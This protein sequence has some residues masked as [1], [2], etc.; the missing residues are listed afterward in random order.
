MHLCLQGVMKKLIE[1]WMV[2]DLTIRFRPTIKKEL[3]RRTKYLKDQVPGDFQRKMRSISYCA[4]WKA[5]KF[6]FF[7]CIVAQLY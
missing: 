6:R 4:K 7:C 1:W 5:T 3:S 2:G